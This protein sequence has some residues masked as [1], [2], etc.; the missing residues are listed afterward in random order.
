M[1]VILAQLS[2]VPRVMQIYDRA[3]AFMRSLGNLTQWKNGYPS[4]AIL[5]TDIAAGRCFLVKMGENT[6]GVFTFSIGEEETYRYIEDGAW[7]SDKP[8]G[9]IHRLASS[10]E[11]RGVLDTA[12]DYC[13]SQIDEIRVDTHADNAPMLGALKKRG[14]V[15]RGRI[16]VADGTPREAFSFAAKKGKTE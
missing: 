7:D 9:V 10:G 4:E 3:R 8:Y 2:D 11:V 1:T 15:R 14:F 6:C 5:K 16:Y 13:L 12:L